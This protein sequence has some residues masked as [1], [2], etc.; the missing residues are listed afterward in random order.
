MK[1]LKEGKYWSTLTNEVDRIKVRLSRKF[2]AARSQG[3][4]RHVVGKFK[5]VATMKISVKDS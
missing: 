1:T 4:G 2:R 5:R 3:K